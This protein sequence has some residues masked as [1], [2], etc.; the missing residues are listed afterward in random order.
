MTEQGWLEIWKSEVPFPS[1]VAQQLVG[2]NWLFEGTFSFL[3]VLWPSSEQDTGEDSSTP[4]DI[5]TWIW[6]PQNSR[7]LGF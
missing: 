4:K 7:S 5:V 3:R 2:S 1:A 6:L